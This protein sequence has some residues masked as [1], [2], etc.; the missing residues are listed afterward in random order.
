[1]DKAA[2]GS[3]GDENKRLVFL[4]TYVGRSFGDGVSPVAQW[5]N[6]KL[7]EISENFLKMEY[8]VREDMC[9]PMQILHGGIAATILDD[10]VGTVVY[11]MGREFAYTSVNLNCDYLHAGRIGDILIV[12]ARVIRA[13]KNIV[14]TEGVIIGPGGKV[15]AK[16][17]SNL[18]Q[19][20]LRLPF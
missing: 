17:T 6:G 2:D 20:S 18:I 10:V 7:L 9:N 3:V 14:H 12:E 1:M 13:G 19:T 16:C 5:L 15:I 8:F 11:A 4:Q